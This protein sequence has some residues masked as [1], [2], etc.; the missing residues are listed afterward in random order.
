MASLCRPQNVDSPEVTFAEI[1]V[2]F[3][4]S[5]KVNVS[6][7]QA[8]QAFHRRKQGPGEKAHEYLAAHRQL[9]GPCSFTDFDRS[10]KDQLIL[11]C[12]DEECAAELDRNV[13]TM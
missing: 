1:L 12:L 7:P 13:T 8:T 9:A 10:L 4:Q 11:G 5:F 6:E 2:R 3:D